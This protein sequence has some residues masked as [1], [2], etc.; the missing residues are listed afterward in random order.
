MPSTRAS[1][2]DSSSPE[3]E[4]TAAGS[5]R[6][7]DTSS[8]KGSRKAAKQ[9]TIEESLAGANTEVLPK[10]SDEDDEMKKNLAE[11]DKKNGEEQTRT[12]TD[13]EKEDAEMEETLA[14]DDDKSN[15]DK[16]AETEAET[17]N[18]KSRTDDISVKNSGA[19][20]ESTETK[21]DDPI[22]ESSQ[23]EKNIASNILEKGIVYFFTRNR[24]GIEDSESV[25]DLART[26][27]VLRSLPI[28]TKL[29]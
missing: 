8:P 14:A 2:R 9:T 16:Q 15:G 13:T 27:F 1:A 21:K 23:R 4:E 22:Q 3:K 26:Y 10:K 19:C 12:E 18:E 20:V 17:K 6:K 28:G 5:K 29:G 7:A 25:G 11:D 24:V